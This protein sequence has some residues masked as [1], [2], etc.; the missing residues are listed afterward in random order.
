M[1]IRLSRELEQELRRIADSRAISVER[2]IEEAVR[3][4]LERESAEYQQRVQKALSVVGK[5][6]LGIRDLAENHD[7]YLSEEQ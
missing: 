4:L 3:L 1:P 7:L 2:L 5:Y 6:H